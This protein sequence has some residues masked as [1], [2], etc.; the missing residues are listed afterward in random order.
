MV[1]QDPSKA[2]VFGITTVPSPD[3][4]SWIHKFEFPLPLPI[5]KSDGLGHPPIMVE[6]SSS[7]LPVNLKV[8]IIVK[9]SISFLLTKVFTQSSWP[10]KLKA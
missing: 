2:L 9:S 8:T 6:K 4:S 10:S 7:M 1:C 3:W 5:K